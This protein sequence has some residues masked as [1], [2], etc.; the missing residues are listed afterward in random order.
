MIKKNL[1]YFRD[2]NLDN[3]NYKELSKFFTIKSI[4]RL[5]DIKLIPNNEKKKSKNYFVKTLTKDN[6]IDNTLLENYQFESHGF[7]WF[8]TYRIGLRETLNWLIRLKD[9]NK[10]AEIDYNILLYSFA[11]YVSQ[12]RDGIMI[13]Q[14]EM[15]RLSD[16]GITR[17]DFKFAD[18]PGVKELISFGLSNEL[19]KDIVNSLQES[20]G[21]SE[22]VAT[23]LA[24]RGIET[25]IQAKKFFRPKLSD[26]Y[27]PFLMKDMD[28]AVARIET[29]IANNENI[30]VYGDYDVDGTTSVALV[31]SYLKTQYPNVAT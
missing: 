25:Y 7:A 31:A 17:D 26:L 9:S 19:K 22:L 18:E 10:A 29:A 5:S 6:R 23:L 27:N 24:Q 30:L 8:E 3:S 4:N 12:M 2:I 15:V 14:T 16:I 1:L 28:K 21:V 13:S 20:L 11:E